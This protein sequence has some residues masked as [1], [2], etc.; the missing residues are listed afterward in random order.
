MVVCI[1][2]PVVV[3]DFIRPDWW[4]TTN[5]DI[6]FGILV[7]L[8]AVPNV[9]FWTGIGRIEFVFSDK[10]RSKMTCKLWKFYRETFGPS[11]S[12]G[13]RQSRMKK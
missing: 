2:V 9:L 5:S 10:D 3:L 12:D 1:A 6:A 11:M 4:S 7:I 8:V 13:S